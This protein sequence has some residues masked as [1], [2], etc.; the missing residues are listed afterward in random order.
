MSLSARLALTLLAGLLPAACATG[1]P[2][3]DTPEQQAGWWNGCVAGWEEA[4]RDNIDQVPQRHSDYAT[5]RAYR[6]S[7]HDGF[8]H[9]FD[10][11]IRT[12]RMIGSTSR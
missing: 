9:C 3:G 8:E 10:E 4:G 5:N 11:E 12:P 7:W 6:D 1:W 2:P